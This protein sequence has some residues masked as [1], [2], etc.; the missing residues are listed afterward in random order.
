[1]TRIKMASSDDSTNQM[2]DNT[3]DW[4][5]TTG[6]CHCPIEGTKR[7]LIAFRLNERRAVIH[8]FMF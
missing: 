3:S 7:T 8:L 4:T 1:M 5:L 2:K 6:T